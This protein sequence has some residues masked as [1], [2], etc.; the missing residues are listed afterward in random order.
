DEGV[1][2]FTDMLAAYAASPC[3]P[4]DLDLAVV[5]EAQDLSRLQWRVVMKAFAAARELVVGGDDMQMIHHWAGAD[6]ERFL[7]LL[8]DGFEI[9]NLPISHRLPRA[10]FAL[11]EEVGHRIER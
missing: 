11:A 8:A 6:E 10:A 2:D 9:E 4:L 3:Q 1:L 5:D 7:G